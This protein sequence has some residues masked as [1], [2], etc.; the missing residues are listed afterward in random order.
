MHFY[1]NRYLP[2]HRVAMFQIAGMFPMIYPG[3]GRIVTIVPGI[4]I[5]VITM[6][7][8][9]EINTPAAGQ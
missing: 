3:V 9:A 6:I 2:L 1:P 8:R 5:P 4:P 7:P